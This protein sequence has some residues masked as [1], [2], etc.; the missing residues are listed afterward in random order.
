MSIKPFKL[1]LIQMHVEGGDKTRNLKHAVNL[2]SKATKN[3]AQFVLLPETLDLG[4]THPSS[5]TEAEP[6]PNGFPCKTLAKSAIENNI[7]I[8]AG[9]TE[10]TPDKIYNSAVIIDKKGNVKCLHRKINELKIGLDYY[11]IGD[12]LNV[13]KTEFGTIGLMICADAQVK[14]YC[15]TKAL[16]KMG[17][18]IILSPCAWAVPADHD[19]IKNPYG[20]EWLTAYSAI[21]KDFSVWIASVTNVGLISD[22]PWKN[23]NCIG[24]SLVVNPLGEEFV[25]GPYGKDADTILYVDVSKN[26]NVDK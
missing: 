13:V 24:C 16:C 26:Y 22:G 19:N 12:R 21:A 23:W 3:G 18:D 11:N 5:L 9:L 7:Y 15:L 6:I 1:A 8:C 2:I 10:K 17:A 14:D 4:W 20:K 25:K